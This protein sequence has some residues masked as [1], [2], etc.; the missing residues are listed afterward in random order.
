MALTQVTICKKIVTIGAI[1]SELQRPT[2]GV[3]RVGDR[4]LA[5]PRL[6][7]RVI[8]HVTV[9]AKISC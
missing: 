1:G 8:G 2:H 9:S 7:R 6:C 3:Q 4:D 5:L